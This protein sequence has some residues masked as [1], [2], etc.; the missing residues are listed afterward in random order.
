MCVHALDSANRIAHGEMAQILVDSTASPATSMMTMMMM[1]TM[2]DILGDI[3]GPR[4]LS[5]HN[6]VATQSG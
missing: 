6:L 2:I 3:L 5:G 4:C 1:M